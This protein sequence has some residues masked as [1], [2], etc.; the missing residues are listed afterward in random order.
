[1]RI[2]GWAFIVGILALVGS[3]LVCA[4][5]SFGFTRQLVI[6]MSA[7]GISASSPLE[8]VNYVVQG[9]DPLRTPQ[10]PV[11][12]ENLPTL[13]T[14]PTQIV[15][16]PS[17]TIPGSTPAPT[18]EATPAAP[19]ATVDPLLDNPILK[20]PRRKNILILGIDQRDA[21]QD[22]GPFRT[23]T[24]ILVT[25]DPVRKT[26]GVISIPR[27][28]W[29]TIPGFEAGRINTANSLGDANAYPGGGGPALAAAT[30]SA[31]LGIPVDKYI[32]VN[33]H[34]FTTIVDILAPDG[35]EINVTEVIDD[36]KYPDAGYGTIH[37]HFDP[38]VQRLNAEQ[39]LQ[40]A[41]TRATFGG[42][43]DRAKRQQ[44]VIDALRER[45]LSVGGIG[46]FVTQAPA[47]W[48]ELKDSYKTNLSLQEI[49]GLG[50][51]MNEIPRENI[52]FQ[53]IDNHYVDLAKNAAG[54]DI[55]LLRQGAVGDL[56]Q[57]V[58]NPQP[59]LTVAD[60]K[61]R[62]DAEA[63]TIL[64]YN[65]TD[66]SGLATQTREWLQSR[67]V[68]VLNVGN[69]PTPSNSNTVIR[70][71]TGKEWTARYLAA[72]LNLPLDRIEPGSDRLTTEDIVVVV[73]PDIQP[74]LSG[75]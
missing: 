4:V 23:D 40:Y 31:N 6:D 5:A 75:Q 42:D 24:M 7:Q 60:L 68:N 21:V 41:R 9:A 56:I 63:A 46:S 14:V 37:V 47:I 18:I 19:T 52:V 28:L 45:L 3:T 20:D 29:V 39:L 50:L 2:P 72:L 43:F 25:V 69:M 1:M 48:D 55:L 38:G 36:P 33:F 51:L 44:E 8:L 17:A 70:Y 62:A 53:V 54:D 59:D 61:T 58:F 64:V 16:N 10:F 66:I 22:P 30:V 11:V 12:E 73:G 67:G 57:R 65:N 49:I 27:D 13:T 74:L 32:L 71:Y 34:V 26:A 35:I 15:A